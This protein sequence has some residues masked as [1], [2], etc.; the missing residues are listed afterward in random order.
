[1]FTIRPSIHKEQNSSISVKQVK[2]N[3]RPKIRSQEEKKDLKR[4]TE[5]KKL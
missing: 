4:K 1:M 5:T 3:K 2:L